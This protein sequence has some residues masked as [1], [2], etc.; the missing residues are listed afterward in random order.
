M[1]GSVPEPTYKFVVGFGESDA[2]AADA[3]I[4]HGDAGCLRD[5]FDSFVNS[6]G[7]RNTGKL[8]ESGS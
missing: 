8:V 2:A 1:R 7:F 3:Q 5:T 4:V 6:P